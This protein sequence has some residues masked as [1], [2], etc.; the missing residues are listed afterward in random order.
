MYSPQDNYSDDDDDEIMERRRRSRSASYF[1]NN[2]RRASKINTY[3]RKSKAQFKKNSFS[4]D[5]GKE[6]KLSI[7]SQRP[8]SPEFD[9]KQKI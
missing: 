2:N 4:A 8:Q 1:I 5:A 7:D 6:D 9:L 3:R